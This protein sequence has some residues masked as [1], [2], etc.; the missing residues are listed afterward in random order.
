[1]RFPDDMKDG[2]KPP[3]AEVSISFW[4]DRAM[5]RQLNAFAHR[6]HTDRSSVIRD[7][8]IEHMERVKAYTSIALPPEPAPHADSED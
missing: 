4:I 5:A 3:H 6:R 1:M 8:L 2:H 7:A